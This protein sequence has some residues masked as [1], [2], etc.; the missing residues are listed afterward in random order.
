MQGAT[1]RN[2]ADLFDVLPEIEKAL[3]GEHGQSGS[4][5]ELELAVAE[6]GPDGLVVLQEVRRPEIDGNRREA[7]QLHPGYRVVVRSDGPGRQYGK[8]EAFAD[9]ALDADA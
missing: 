2:V 7:Q 8:A 6:E 3:R 4:A 9:I 1:F 5:G